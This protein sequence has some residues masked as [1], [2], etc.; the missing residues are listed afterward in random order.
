MTSSHLLAPSDRILRQ[1]SGLWLIVFGALSA[2]HA[3]RDDRPLAALIAILALTVGPLGLVWP[4]L[5]KPIFVAWM[6]I[7]SP[8]GWVVSHTF[9]AIAFYGLF[10]PVAFIFRMIGRDALELRRRSDAVTYWHVKPKASGPWQY[11]R[12]F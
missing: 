5:V 7:A 1:F 11:F 6:R 12:Q 2:L 3:F 4:R 8:I 10:T 9:L